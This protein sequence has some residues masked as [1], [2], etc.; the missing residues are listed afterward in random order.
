M[1]EVIFVPKHL[2][3]SIMVYQTNTGHRASSLYNES[4]A[5]NKFTFKFWSCHAFNIVHQLSSFCA[6][7]FAVFAD[8]VVL[9]IFVLQTYSWNHSTI[10]FVCSPL[11]SLETFWSICVT[12]V[13]KGILLDIGFNLWHSLVLQSQISNFPHSLKKCVFCVKLF[14]LKNFTLSLNEAPKTHYFCFV[15]L[16]QC[17]AVQQKSNKDIFAKHQKLFLL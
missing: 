7:W 16:I 14:S 9:L 2:V 10:Y 1:F 6:L 13:V 5:Q 12:C 15:L 3:M 17:S 4:N 11:F 8:E